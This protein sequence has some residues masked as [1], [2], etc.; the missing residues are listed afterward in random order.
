MGNDFM[1]LIPAVR[2]E[3]QGLHLESLTTPYNV[4]N[5]PLMSKNHALQKIAEG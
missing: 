2:L 5:F 1:R 3:E 4:E